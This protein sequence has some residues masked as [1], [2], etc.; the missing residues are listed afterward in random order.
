MQLCGT[1]FVNLYVAFLV[2]KR[3]PEIASCRAAILDNSEKS[4]IK[5]DAVALVISRLGHVALNGTD[6]IIISAVVGVLW[7]G[8]LSNYTLICDSVT[9]VLCQITAAITGSL[10]NYF[11]TENRRSGYVIFKKIEF[12]NFWL[13]GFSFIA[14]LILLDP[15]IRLWAGARFV[16]GLPVCFAIALN[17]FV[18]GYMNTLWVFR[19]TLGLFKQGKYRPLIVAGLNIVLSIALGKIWGV[20]GVLFATFLSR[21]AVNLWY[22][23]IV[24]HKYGFGVSAKPFFCEYAKR[25]LLVASLSILLLAVRKFVFL[26]GVSILGFVIMMVITAIVPNA[27]FW[28][29]YHKK[30][31]YL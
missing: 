31:E 15:F 20:F 26:T 17:F 6:N 8:R 16:L 21:A 24:L 23:P 2:D 22:D 3:Y 25:L 11:A 19:S 9:S 14:L 29:A 1:V 7:V 13:Y 18:A 28:I 30:N 5:K 12:L 27:M 10:G 4:Q